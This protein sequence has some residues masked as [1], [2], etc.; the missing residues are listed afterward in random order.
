MPCNPKDPNS[1]LY[2]CNSKNICVRG[3]GGKPCSINA[4]CEYRCEGSK[5]VQGGTGAPCTPGCSESVACGKTS[6]A[7]TFPAA[8]INGLISTNLTNPTIIS[9]I[10]LLI[11]IVIAVMVLRKT[12]KKKGNKKE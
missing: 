2:G 11:I 12:Y 9:I 1:C 8:I 10:I 4:D 5:C 7:N 3:G 6:G